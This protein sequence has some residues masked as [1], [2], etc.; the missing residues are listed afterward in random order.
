MTP[1]IINKIIIATDTTMMTGRVVAPSP[2]RV[3]VG[4]ILLLMIVVLVL[5]HWEVLVGCILLLQTV[6]VTSDMAC[7]IMNSN[8]KLH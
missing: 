8:V 6:V 1:T 4:C 7:H 3:L 2:Q 5:T